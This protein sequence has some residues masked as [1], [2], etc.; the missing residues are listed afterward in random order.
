MTESV[1]LDPATKVV[2]VS[3]AVPI[4]ESVTAPRLV[5][6]SRKVTVPVGALVFA[7]TVA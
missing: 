5:A 4:A 3:E 2:T 6:P 1:W 7:D